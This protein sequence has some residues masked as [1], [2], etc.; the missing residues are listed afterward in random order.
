[1]LK[2]T[3]GE[4]NPGPF[5]C[6]ANVIPLHHQPSHNHAHSQLTSS[7]RSSQLPTSP[8]TP[9]PTVL[10]Q[11]CFTLS[12]RLPTKTLQ[13]Q[14]PSKTQQLYLL[15]QYCTATCV[16]SAHCSYSFSTFSMHQALL[17]FPAPLHQ[18]VVSSSKP[19]APKLYGLTIFSEC[20]ATALRQKP[21][22]V[23]GN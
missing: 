3:D 10:L 11:H 16:A 15:S 7:S 17:A 13:F 23:F 21:T 1:M 6:E 22:Q 4:L 8:F 2:S 5:A 14:H 19:I 9:P 18:A 20:K 12:T